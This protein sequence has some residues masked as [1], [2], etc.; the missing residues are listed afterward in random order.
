MFILAQQSSHKNKFK[1]LAQVL[2][3]LKTSPVVAVDQ[4]WQG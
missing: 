2:V 3:T 4:S 1:M